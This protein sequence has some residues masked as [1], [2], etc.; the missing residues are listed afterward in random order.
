MLQENR[1][2]ILLSFL[3]LLL[4]RQAE[5]LSCKRFTDNSTDSVCGGVFSSISGYKYY[6]SG[7]YSGISFSNPFYG[8]YMHFLTNRISVTFL[9]PR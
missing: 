2:F 5:S 6:D 8:R 4:V 7:L 1:L 9:S 3:F